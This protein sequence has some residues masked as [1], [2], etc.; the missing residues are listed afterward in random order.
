MSVDDHQI[1]FD[2]LFFFSSADESAMLWEQDEELS[3]S[4]QNNTPTI[5]SK[6]TTPSSSIES[7]LICGVCG[8]AAHGYNFDRVTCE[9]CKAFFRRN[10]LKDTV[11]RERS[12]SIDHRSLPGRL[13]SMDLS[14]LRFLS[15]HGGH[16]SSMCILSFE[17]MFSNWN[18]KGL[19]SH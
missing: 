19:D 7:D 12:A 4:S 6:S 8:A 18:E 9:S 17:E 5:P 16:T 3:S 13:V 10:A 2:S 15:D 14:I 1:D 11:K